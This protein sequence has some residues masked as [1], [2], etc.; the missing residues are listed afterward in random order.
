M[1]VDRRLIGFGL[2]L[3]TIGAVM[4]ADRQGLLSEDAARQS[5][6]LWPLIL[7][8]VGLSIVVAGRPGAAIGGLIVAVT[9][10][11]MIGGV[12][13]GGA[14][15]AVGLC[16]GERGHGAGFDPRHGDLGQRSSVSID[17]DC[18]DL[19]VGMGGGTGWSVSGETRDGR[20]PRIEAGDGTL[21]I[22]SPDGAGFLDPG[23]SGGWDVVLGRDATIDLAMTLNGGSGSVRLGGATVGRL[24]A[25]ANAGSIELDLRDIAALG[26]AAIDVNFGS[27]TVHLP[28]HSVSGSLSVNA[29]SAALCLPAGAGLRVS[30]DL[31]AA[32]DDLG[33]HGLVQVG[34]AWETPGY[35]SAT[36]RIDLRADVNAGSL[37]LD[38]ARHCA[39]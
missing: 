34:G 37:A 2:F 24:R 23:G 22:A 36:V 5:W 17:Q 4:V 10:G 25:E 8:G 16:G 7:V 12:V 1:H 15:P 13:A 30:L 6:T 35:D 31:A 18:G 28:N 29:G 32:S 38:P 19:T 33:D 26:D 14:F 20:S 27:A 39:G 9:A 3:I 21:R 11:A